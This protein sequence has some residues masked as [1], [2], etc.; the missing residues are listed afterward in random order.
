MVQQNV[1]PLN[2]QRVFS[3][4]LIT[5]LNLLQ[6]NIFKIDDNATPFLNKNSTLDCPILLC[7]NYL[8]L[9]FHSLVNIQPFFDLVGALFSDSIS[10]VQNNRTRWNSFNSFFLSLF[11]FQ[12][13]V[14]IISIKWLS[15]CVCAF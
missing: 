13:L 15:V 6:K 14:C 4:S 5:T 11:P 3:S 10:C 9:C 12:N 2:T 7:F 8:T 1:S